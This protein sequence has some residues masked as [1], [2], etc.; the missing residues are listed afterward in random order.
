M[1]PS[2]VMLE[3][4]A[5]ARENLIRRYADVKRRPPKYL[6]N[7]VVRISRE[8]SIFEKGYESGWTLELFRID[9]LS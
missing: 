8:K 1:A 4:A 9:R 2:A 3:N 5:V 6:F 7:D